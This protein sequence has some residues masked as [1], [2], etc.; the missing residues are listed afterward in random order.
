MG[1]HGHHIG[2]IHADLKR[3]KK[4]ANFPDP[5]EKGPSRSLRG[6][7]SKP[8]ALVTWSETRVSAVQD[9]ERTVSWARNER[10][11]LEVES[12]QGRTGGEN[13]VPGSDPPASELGPLGDPGPARGYAGHG[14]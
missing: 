6:T 10:R 14:W 5:K 8:Q 4:P 2:C 11:P 7:V 13:S 12:A 9:R 1:T 3:K